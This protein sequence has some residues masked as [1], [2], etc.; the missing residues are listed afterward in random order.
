MK[1][2]N[3][4]T[5]GLVFFALAAVSLLTLYYA[6]T[7]VTRH[8]DSV[9]LLEAVTSI[10]QGGKPISATVQ[11]WPEV[12]RTLGW[13]PER[14][15]AMALPFPDQ[16]GYNVLYNHAY[17]ALYPIALLAALAGTEA[18]FALMN[19]VAHLALVLTPF[20]FLRR[21]GVPVASA[22]IF[23]LCVACYPGWSLSANGDYYLDR[24]YMPFMLLLLY[25]LDSWVRTGGTITRRRWV[26][27]AVTTAVAASIMTERATIM[28]IGTLLFFWAAFPAFRAGDSRMGRV[29]LAL[30]IALAAYLAWYFAALFQGFE[31]GGSLT[32]NAR[33]TLDAMHAR[34]RHP[35]MPA[36]VLTNLL[37]I[38]WLALF[39]GWRYLLLLL[40][41]MLPNLLISI[42]G[43]ELAG[44]TTHYHAMYIPFLIFAASVG[45]LELTRQ[46]GNVLA[47]AVPPLAGIG[48]V[49]LAL[50]FNPYTS[51][52]VKS[53]DAGSYV[54]VTTGVYRFFV[55]PKLSGQKAMAEWLRRLDA[56]IP[57]GVKVS[58][59]EGAMPALYGSRQLALYPAGL[60]DADYLVVSGS[61]AN[62]T[63]VAVKG[64]PSSQGPAAVEQL[65]ACLATR[66]AHQGFVLYKDI[67]AIGVL[68]FKKKAS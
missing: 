49:L 48:A 13:L 5:W 43:A 3:A 6:K 22:A 41:A 4:G 28:V 18:A 17:F 67:A 52:L 60:D 26:A 16:P 1:W 59:I 19:A 8:L 45:Y 65:D 42:G 14:V 27:A 66:A 29:V 31:G 55:T 62:G 21:Q 39:S 10:S 47:L 36:F 35:L 56:V 37:F 12:A 64:A 34:L 51:R 11:S 32:Q 9:F 33:L 54:Y 2:R 50:N 58:A 38:G 63:P 7:T 57:A 44:W 68:V 24:L 53:S 46:G 25:V 40:G 30:S 61:S 15:C 23:S 20:I